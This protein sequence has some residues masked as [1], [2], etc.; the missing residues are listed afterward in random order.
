MKLLLDFLPLVFF[1][2]TY[3]VAG[4]HADA[5]AAFA[6]HW[7]GGIVSG[8]IVGPKEA[9]VLLATVVV[10]AATLLQV[11]WMRLN[12]RKIDLMLWV[13]LVVV[14]LFG[15]MAIYFH[16]ETFIKWKPSIVCWTMGLVFWSSQTF[17]HRN[18]LRSTLSE[19]IEMPDRIWQRLNFAWVAYFG[20]MGLINLWVAYTF[21]TDAWANFH[22]FGS[23]GLSVLFFVGQVFYMNRHMEP[24]PADKP[25]P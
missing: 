5:A 9:P 23:V 12:R 1:F 25:A 17:F 10:I 14:V 13:S 4:A 20:L 7:L 6:T 8:G 19:Q 11:V 24:V 15:G 2:V 3:K 21:S 16:N 18:L 22:S